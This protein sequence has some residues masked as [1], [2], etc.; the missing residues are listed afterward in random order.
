[1]HKIRWNKFSG[2]VNW[3][4]WYVKVLACVEPD[5]EQSGQTRREDYVMESSSFELWNWSVICSY[6]V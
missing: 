6:N 4:A 2:K 1:M 3:K 5:A